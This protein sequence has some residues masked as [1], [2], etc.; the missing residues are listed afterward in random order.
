VANCAYKLHNVHFCIMCVFAIVCVCAFARLL[1]V[2]IQAPTEDSGAQ[3]ALQ[4]RL[5]STE[6]ELKKLQD[7]YKKQRG[8]LQV[9]KREWDTL[10]ALNGE[11]VIQ[12]EAMRIVKEVRIEGV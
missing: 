7:K 2:S 8:E 6:E 3:D 1:T 11:L 5:A 9:T 12:N 4:V 10:K